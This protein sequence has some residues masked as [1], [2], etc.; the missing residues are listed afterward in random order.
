MSEGGLHVAVLIYLKH[1]CHVCSKRNI[2]T[3]RTMCL[4]QMRWGNSSNSD[5]TVRSAN[6]NFCCRILVGCYIV[7]YLPKVVISL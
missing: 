5:W 6:C 3:K 4:F 2:S 7:L 1:V